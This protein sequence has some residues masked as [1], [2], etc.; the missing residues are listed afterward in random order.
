MSQNMMDLDWVWIHCNHF[1][2]DGYGGE[3]VT[4]ECFAVV[5]EIQARFPDL[6]RCAQI[7][8]LSN[9]TF[10]FDW[11]ADCGS[12]FN[13]EIGKERYSAFCQNNISGSVAYYPSPTETGMNAAVYELIERHVSKFVGDFGIL[14]Q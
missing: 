11:E 1:D 14:G 12:W 4:D 9:G 7:C 10:S 6:Y 3:P 8:P 5:R 2:W 13:L